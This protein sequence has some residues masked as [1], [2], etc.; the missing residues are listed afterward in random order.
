MNKTNGKR[1]CAVA[2]RLIQAVTVTLVMIASA[3]TGQAKSGNRFGVDI[4][5]FGQVNQNYYRGAQPDQQGFAQL[6]ALGIKTVI[7]LQGDGKPEEGDWVRNAGMQFFNIPLSSERPA[8]DEQTAYFLKLVNDSDN[9]PVYV[10]CAGG[11]HRT[12][13]MT[14]IYRITADGW[15]ADQAYQEMKKYQWYSRWGHGPLKA[16][17]YDYY[18]R[19]KSGL[20]A[21]VPGRAPVERM[22]DSSVVSHNKDDGHLRVES[23]RYKDGKK[24][25]ITGIGLSQ[26]ADV[27]V[28]GSRIQGDAAFDASKR[29]LVIRKG[30]AGFAAKQ[31]GVNRIEITEGAHATTFDF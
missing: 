15:T 11:R 14:A 19:Y 16:Y 30:A 3:L 12:G 29:Q 13:E 21:G 28:N 23:V 27:I 9:W 25:I 22:G 10:H 31:G 8:T 5:N 26:S 2:Y 4:E 20:I 18:G 1:D 6:K 24:L 7:D 17:M